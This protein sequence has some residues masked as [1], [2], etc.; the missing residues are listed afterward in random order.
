M[1][2]EISSL[3]NSNQSSVPSDFQQYTYVI[4]YEILKYLRSKR[5]IA[6]IIIIGLI[7]GLILIIPPAFGEEYPSDALDFSLI[8][9]SFAGILAFLCFTFFGADAIVS[10]FQHRTGYMLFPNPLKRS[11]ILFGK[12][13][14]SFLSSLLV[15]SIFYGII[16]LSTVIVTKS[17]PMEIGLSFLFCLLYLLSGL[18]VAYLIS[19]LMK[20]TTGAFVLTFFLFFMILPIIDTVFTFAAVKPSFSVSFSSGIIAFILIVPY[21]KDIVEEISMGGEAT[22]DIHQF[23]PDVAMSLV[24]MLFYFVIPFILTYFIF[25]RK[26]MK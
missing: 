6:I 5:L 25:S 8:F 23:Y 15:I 20:G 24:V 4:R 7:I 22:M 10:E 21:P 17:L 13:T 2:S 19:S 16:S 26:E 18:S 11:V 9:V 3:E 1:E 12:F 14:A